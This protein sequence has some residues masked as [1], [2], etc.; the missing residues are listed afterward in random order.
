MPAALFLLHARAAERKERGD[1]RKKKA[2][3]ILVF[4]K[5]IQG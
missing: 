4:K 2:E 5:H 3:G 1:E